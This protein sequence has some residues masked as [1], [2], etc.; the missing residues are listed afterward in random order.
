MIFKMV[1]IATLL[2]SAKSFQNQNLLI[3]IYFKGKL[4]KIHIFILKFNIKF[5]ET[6]YLITNILKF[7]SYFSTKNTT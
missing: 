3:S 5:K 4:I 7:F 1:F 6:N 2:Y